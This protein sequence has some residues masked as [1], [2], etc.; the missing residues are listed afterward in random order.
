MKR[1][2]NWGQKS[3]QAI[4]DAKNSLAN[5]LSITSMEEEEKENEEDEECGKKNPSSYF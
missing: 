4:P 3:C 1:R 2:K 5:I